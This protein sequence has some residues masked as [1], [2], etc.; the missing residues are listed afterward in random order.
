MEEGPNAGVSGIIDLPGQSAAFSVWA[1][2]HSSEL[3]AAMLD[4]AGRGDSEWPE[5][6]PGSSSGFISVGAE[7]ALDG[8]PYPSKFRGEKGTL[9]VQLHT[10]VNITYTVRVV[11]ES[12]GKPNKE[13]GLWS[14]TLVCQLVADPAPAGFTGTQP[15]AATESLSDKMLWAGLMTRVD[16]QGLADAAGRRLMVWGVS[17]ND[18]AEKSKID[19]VLA[20]IAAPFSTLKL[21]GGSFTRAG[22]WAAYIDLE[23]GLT[24]TAE[25]VI[26]PRTQ[27]TIDPSALADQAS[28]AAINGT[29]PTPSGA[30]FVARDTTTA[31]LNDQKTLS[32]TQWG[33]RSHEQDVTMPGTIT[34][35]DA[36]Q[37]EDEATVTVVTASGTPPSI[38]AAPLGQHLKTQ[39]E[40]LNPGKWRHTFQYGV[41]TSKQAVE[42][43][44]TDAQTDASGLDDGERITVKNESSTPPATPSATISGVKLRRTISRRIAGTP[45][46]WSHTFIFDRRTTEDDVEMDGTATTTEP[47][48]LE[49]QGTITQV[50]TSG[51]PP[52]TPSAPVAGALYRETVTRQRHDGKW[53]HTFVYRARTA[54]DDAILPHSW[55]K[56]DPSDIDS[57]GEVA[58]I[59][60]TPATPGS[61]KI[62]D[63]TGHYLTATEVLNVKKFGLNSV[64]DD[65]K[66][67]HTQSSGHPFDGARHAEATVTASASS[68]AVLAA[69]HIVANAASLTYD[70]VEV[71][72]LNDGQAVVVAKTRDNHIIVSFS[73]RASGRLLIP[74]R[75]ISGEVYF[76]L[77]QKI[78]VGTSLWHMHIAEQWHYGSRMEFTVEKRVSGSGTLPME[79]ST[80]GTSNSDTFLGLEIGKVSY[81]GIDGRVNYTAATPAEIAYRF[82]YDTWGI[83]DYKKGRGGWQMTTTDLS[84]LTEGTWVKAS[85]LGF[86][87]IILSGVNYS[88]TFL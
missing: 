2:A 74:A 51:T 49:A 42:F 55:T 50:T 62:R 86:D 82:L 29:P 43:G 83:I 37:L 61:Y 84:A 5:M 67:R 38:P 22:L 59:N 65:H 54:A 57:H 36:T 72:K 27:T 47:F 87:S 73:M 21:R 45:E 39:T 13:S 85:D 20:A 68:A 88:G 66:Y 31:E 76:Y 26:N 63:V 75:V 18:A 17:D 15:T 46:G 10:G 71:H 44:G 69:A 30:S 70:G 64:A 16:P 25:D 7:I 11:K 41:T 8:W 24:D 4:A 6:R 14:M 56:E 58:A 48:E 28:S 81:L 77:A 35:D 34:G 80:T 1:R 19:N 60:S 32:T 78:Q 52:A 33:L 12:F 3:S 79:W 23:W 53:A 9:I 40:Q